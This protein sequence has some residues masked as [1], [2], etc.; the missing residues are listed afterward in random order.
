[1]EATHIE[2]KEQQ[3]T[4]VIRPKTSL[5]DL[6]LK[7]VWQYRDLLW[8]FVT[9]DFIATYKQT[10]LGPL[11]FFIQPVLTA[12]TYSIIFGGIA[13]IATDGLPRMLF[14]ISG[15]TVWTYF[16][17][18]LIK[19]SNVFIANARIFGK[20]YFPR[21][22]MPLSIVTSG[23]IKLGIQMLLFLAV[24]GYY[25]ANGEPFAL[26]WQVVLLPLLIAISALL[27]LGLGMIISSMTTKYRDLA[28]LLTF[29]THLWMYATPVIYPS[30]RIKGTSFAWVNE[31][32]PVAP[33]VE[34]FRYMFT[35]VG[36]YS[37]QGLVYSAS[38]ALI[39]LTIGTLTFNKVEKSFMDT[40]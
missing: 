30:S 32:N 34:A 18:S 22:I 36:T 39:I 27:A 20:V 3:W 2:E 6:R 19:T 17:D 40:V 26:Q 38:V 29:G 24:W 7:E 11:W 4:E 33:I 37:L 16:N 31:Y 12:I 8:M 5:F 10:I 23:L 35:G 14:Y 13:G 1:M 28:Q 21:L 9:R 25:V 15:I